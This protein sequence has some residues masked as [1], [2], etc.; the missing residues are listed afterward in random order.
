MQRKLGPTLAIIGDFEAPPAMQGADP[1]MV[2]IKLA[3]E[4][5]GYKTNYTLLEWWDRFPSIKWW[6]YAIWASKRWAR[7]ANYK[8]FLKCLLTA[9]RG[10]KKF[11]DYYAALG[12]W[13]RELTKGVGAKLRDQLRSTAHDS[14]CVCEECMEAVVHNGQLVGIKAPGKILG[15]TPVLASG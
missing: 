5:L 2:V 10:G 7:G 15:E 14:P 11:E 9:A 3:R 8:Y 12:R 13:A 6:R 1:D 4:T